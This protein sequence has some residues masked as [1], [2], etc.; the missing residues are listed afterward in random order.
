VGVGLGIWADF[1]QE[2]GSHRSVW[3][4]PFVAGGLAGTFGGLIF[5]RWMSEGDFFP[6][7]LGSANFIPV[8]ANITCSS[9]L[10]YSSA[11]PSGCFSSVT[12]AGTALQDGLGARL[13]DL[14]LVSRTANSST[15]RRQNTARLVG[16]NGSEL[17][18]S[19]VWAYLYGLILGVAYA[20][21]DRV[22][23]RAVHIRAIRLKSGSRRTRHSYP[24]F[25]RAGEL[26][27]AFVGSLISSPVMLATG[28]YCR[29]LQD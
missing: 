24:A 19:L 27:L 28:I 6:C 26:W 22:W 12:S 11:P 16:G 4:A 2:G 8:P 29:K 15:H 3:V 13:R 20:T 14:L 21:L 1:A 9:S 17:F 18:G 7:L 25:G 23:V 5:G 10:R